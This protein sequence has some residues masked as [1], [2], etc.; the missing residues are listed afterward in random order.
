MRV[1]SV[2]AVFII[3]VSLTGCTS[4]SEV[5]GRSLKSAYRSVNRIKNRLPTEQR[6]EFELSFWGLRDLYPKKEDFLE[7]VGGKDYEE[8]IV[9]GKEM[10]QQRKG[11]GF[12]AYQKYTSW[13]H[14]ITQY[15]QER[16]D[17]N[18]SKAKKNSKREED[19]SVLYQL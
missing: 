5:S 10:F 15:A 4:G 16:L 18:K 11:D 1:L 12:E 3:A 14:M 9:L 6:I 2:I 19:N 13:E 7:Y 8:I 17:Q